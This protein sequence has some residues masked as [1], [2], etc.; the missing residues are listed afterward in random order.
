MSNVTIN[1]L[2]T[3][4]SIDP[5]QDLLPI[6]TASA[7]ATQSINRNTL[8]G[9]ASAPVG[10]TD[11]QTLTNKTFTSPTISG[12]TLSGTITG[13]YTIG[14]T[15]TFPAS[16][17]TLTGTQTLTNKTLTSPTI[18][19]P[20]ITNAS[21]TADTITGFTT[22]TSGT[23][24]GMSVTTGVLA[25]AALVGSVNS[26]ALATGIQ[27]A[28]VAK[29]PYKFLVYLSTNQTVSASTWTKVNLNTAT[30]DTG[31][32]FDHTTNFQFTAPITG[33][34]LF[35]ACGTMNG[36]ND[37]DLISLGLNVGTFSTTPTYQLS[38]MR[39]GGAS[40]TAALSG[41][42]LLSLTA[43]QTVQLYAFTNQ[44]T[45]VGSTAPTGTYLYGSL[46]SAT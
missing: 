33:F 39:V 9:L 42:V 8:L 45:V 10:L 22:S 5:V 34:Y 31:S 26:A 11:S 29:N 41:S 36:L 40:T 3:A 15:P 20:T 46:M 13:T 2:P 24:Y 19:S 37:G 21:L 35:G 32:N 14:G 25:S 12:P 1:Q 23:I 30:Y 17:T 18:N 28:N 4:N 6:Y 38:Q 7:T 16:V 43:N 44:T 27:V